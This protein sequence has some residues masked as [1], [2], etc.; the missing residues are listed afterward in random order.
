MIEHAL[1]T[2]LIN[3]LWL[4]PLVAVAAALAARFGRLGP[5]GRH[6]AWLAGLVLAVTLPALPA[7]FPPFRPAP[8]APSPV[9]R[10]PALVAPR[11]AGVEI[12]ARCSSGARASCPPLVAARKGGLEARAPTPFLVIDQAWTRAILL[13]A[14]LAVAIALYRLVTA[15]RAGAALARAARP[16]D[17]EPALVRTLRQAAARHGCTLLP[18]L[19]SDQIASPAVVGAWRPA[20]L[21]PPGFTHLLPDEQRAALLHELAHVARRD[22]A[23]NLACEAVSLPAAWHPAIFPIKAGVRK[24]RETACDALAAEAMASR[25]TYAKCLVSLAGQ[26]GGPR[27]TSAVLV[28][29]I[30]KSDLEERLADPA[31]PQARPRRRRPAP[32]RRRGPGRRRADPGNLTARSPRPS[33]ERP[34]L[35]DPWPPSRPSNASRR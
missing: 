12:P 2:W 7:A 4:I 16:V 30:G 15:A 21:I 22:Y 10:S 9:A 1:I 28:G 29:L 17:L 34:S 23:W 18:V 26:L 35:P 25:V 13:V 6:G 33:P 32:R 8:A 5:R 20:I 19:E 11:D 3:A 14:G 31:H 24:S 27:A